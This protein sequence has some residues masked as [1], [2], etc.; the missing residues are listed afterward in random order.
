M[1]SQESDLLPLHSKGTLASSESG[2]C[3]KPVLLLEKAHS[4]STYRSDQLKPLN[5]RKDEPNFFTHKRPLANSIL[6]S[7]VAAGNK[8]ELRNKLVE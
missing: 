6:K 8:L 7:T 1:S 4:V 2:D 5:E 3:T